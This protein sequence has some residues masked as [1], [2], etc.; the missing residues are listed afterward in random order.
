[1]RDLITRTDDFGSAV[2]ANR[3]ILRAVKNGTYV[4]NVS[5]MAAAPCI[6]EGAAE[7]ESLRREKGFCIGLHAALNSEWDAVHF[8]CVSDP[9][10]VSS[11]VNEDGIFPMHPM[12]F[13]QKMPD[14]GEAIKEIAAQ[15]DRL[16]ALGLSVEYVDTHMLP[17]AVVPGLKEALSEF[18]EKKGLVDQRYFYTFP[19]EHQPLLTGETSLEE[20][21]KAYRSWFR[22]LED[23]RQYIHILHPAEYSEETRR[24]CNRVLTGDSVAKSRDAERRILESRELERACEE[25]EIRCIRYTEAKPQGDTIMEAAKNF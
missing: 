14:A 9:A 3:A 12:M 4:K 17:D 20:D 8:K 24:F 10:K 16:A 23:G 22:C 7:L 5:C 25:L 2:S 13:E 1:M 11:L 18:A 6:E 19:K 21:A 15:L